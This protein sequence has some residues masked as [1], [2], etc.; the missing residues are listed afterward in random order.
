MREG[1]GK[2]GAFFID[3]LWKK[4]VLKTH[5]IPRERLGALGWEGETT[6]AKRSYLK[7]KTR[8]PIAN[9]L[10]LIGAIPCNSG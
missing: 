9:F 8:K 4:Q 5:K 7:K 1:L 10:A 6:S 2:Q 3:L